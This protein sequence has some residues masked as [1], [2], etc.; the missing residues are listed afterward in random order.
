VNWFLS[1]KIHTATASQI[2]YFT[3]KWAG[4]VEF[5]GGRGNNRMVKPVGTRQIYVVGDGVDDWAAWLALTVWAAVL[6]F[7]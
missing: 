3:D 4:N 5:A 6:G 1:A 2:K 7:M